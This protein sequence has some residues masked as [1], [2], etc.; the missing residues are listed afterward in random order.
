MGILILLIAIIL[1]FIT[2]KG[3]KGAVTK[4]FAFIFFTILYF[5]IVGFIFMMLG[6][7]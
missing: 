6:G 1:A 7:I 3:Y 4:F 2:S 5:F